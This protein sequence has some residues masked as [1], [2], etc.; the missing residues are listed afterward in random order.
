MQ[1]LLYLVVNGEGG[2]RGEG[3]G[4]EGEEEEGRGGERG[5]RD[6]WRGREV[7][8]KGGEGRR[9]LEGR[10]KRERD[11]SPWYTLEFTLSYVHPLV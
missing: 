8:G 1:P 10:G 7:E 2:G 6:G 4:E 9:G 3:K 11:I 5:M